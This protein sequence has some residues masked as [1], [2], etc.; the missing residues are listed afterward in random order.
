[1]HNI[2][3][4]IWSMIIT[5]KIWLPYC[6]ALYF[7]LNSVETHLYKQSCKWAVHMSTRSPRPMLH[8]ISATL[9]NSMTLSLFV[10]LSVRPSVRPSSKKT[11]IQANSS[12]FKKFHFTQLLAGRRPC[13]GDCR[14]VCREK[15]DAFFTH[16][17]RSH[18]FT[19]VWTASCSC[20]FFDLIE[21]F[22]NP[23]P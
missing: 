2:I 12:K 6:I 3:H 17:A 23:F 22:L 8:K 4:C 14:F 1:M 11:E 19:Q 15:M 5:T 18:L 16:V 21:S 20:I 7:M 9:S 10:L 13:F